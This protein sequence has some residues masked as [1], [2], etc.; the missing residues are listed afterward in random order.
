MKVSPQKKALNFGVNVGGMGLISTPQPSCLRLESPTLPPTMQ[1]WSL[2]IF[3]QQKEAVE[4]G[5]SLPGWKM[6]YL[7]LRAESCLG[8]IW[9]GNR[10]CLASNTFAQKIWELIFIVFHDIL[11]PFHDVL[12]ICI[13]NPHH[14]C[15][16]AVRANEKDQKH[17]H[18]DSQYI[19]YNYS[20][21]SDMVH[22]LGLG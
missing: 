5:F 1:L 9:K 22:H 20:D 4:A 19:W 16:H 17:P 6:G 12:Y 14:F 10:V 7:L 2:A 15:L 11:S 3:V 13:F 8:C 18:A 21:G